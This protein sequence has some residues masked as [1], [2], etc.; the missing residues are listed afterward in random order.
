MK[1]KPVFF[2][3]MRGQR[4]GYMPDE[5]VHYAVRTWAQFRR[6]VKDETSSNFARTYG[7]TRF[8]WKHLQSGDWREVVVAVNAGKPGEF[9]A[10]AAYAITVSSSCARDY[11]AQLRSSR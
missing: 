8:A 11:L 5:V 4:G 9:Y 7:Q 3:T 2:C 6:I 10:R 1:A